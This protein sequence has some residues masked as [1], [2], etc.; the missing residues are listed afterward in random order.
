VDLLIN[1]CN[2][3]KRRLMIVGQ[4]RELAALK[5]LAGP[6]IEFTGWVSKEQ[7]SPLYARCK[8]LLFAAHED[9]G[10]VPLEC[11]SYGRPVIAYGCGGTFETIIPGIT[12]VLFKEQSADSLMQ[13]ILGFESEQTQYDPFVIQANAHLFD[14][15]EF[16]RRLFHFVDLCVEAKRTGR[17]WTQLENRN[18]TTTLLTTGETSHCL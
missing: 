12:G 5:K 10:I 1:A 9:F 15:S 7:L 2:R 6:T 17:R 18:S 14:T 4:G 16:K 3:L 13:A 8:A 11:Q